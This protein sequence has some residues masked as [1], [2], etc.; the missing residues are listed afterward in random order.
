MQSR[1]ALL[2]TLLALGLAL[3]V[4]SGRDQVFG[5]GGR[6]AAR[7][8]MLT[9]RSFHGV[10]VVNGILYAVGGATLSGRDYLDT[11]EAYDPIT[12]RWTV[13]ARMPT[14][15]EGLAVG[16]VNGIL[17][18]LGGISAPVGGR[19]LDMVEAYDPRTDTWTVKAPM[20]THRSE[21]GVG[22]VN[23]VLYAVGGMGSQGASLASLSAR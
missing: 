7:A 10:G 3:V 11:V 20:P 6:W 13:K 5:Q 19:I 2:R 1:V 15:R 17:Y 22:V 8:P 4:V 14:P 23:G 16:V 21:L 18:T 9:P 12:N